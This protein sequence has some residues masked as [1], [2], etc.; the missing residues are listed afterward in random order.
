MQDVAKLGVVCVHTPYG[1]R[2]EDWL[3]GLLAYEAAHAALEKGQQPLLA[4]QADGW[5]C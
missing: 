1:M 5:Y 2:Q 4:I 3:K